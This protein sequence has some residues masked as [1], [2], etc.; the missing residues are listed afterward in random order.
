MGVF[1]NIDQFYLKL[2]LVSVLLSLLLLLIFK[3]GFKN[4]L[5]FFLFW[6]LLSLGFKLLGPGL[7]FLPLVGV[8]VLPKFRW[9][10]QIVSYPIQ[11][12]L[13]C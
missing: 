2:E 11:A 9:T 1:P 12:F 13:C 7:N 10:L 6:F 5:K 8:R 3:V 4:I